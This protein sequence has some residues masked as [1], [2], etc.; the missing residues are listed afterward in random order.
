MR[1]EARL[2]QSRDRSIGL[3]DTQVQ[4]DRGQQPCSIFV[5]VLIAELEF[6]WRRIIMPINCKQPAWRDFRRCIQQRCRLGQRRYVDPLLQ[7]PCEARTQVFRAQVYLCKQGHRR[8]DSWGGSD[9]VA[10]SSWRSEGSPRVLRSDVKAGCL[11][12]ARSKC[13]E[14][15]DRLLSAIQSVAAPACAQA[16]VVTT[17]LLDQTLPRGQCNQPHRVFSL[18]SQG[19]CAACSDIRPWAANR[20]RTNRALPVPATNRH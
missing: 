15:S 10:K 20:A 17:L 9:P 6:P 12:E 13:G 7:E 5:A 11:D 4:I 19:D 14:P 3:V 18:S 16:G 2:L 8:G 1:R